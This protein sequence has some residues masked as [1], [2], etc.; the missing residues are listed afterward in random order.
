MIR[1]EIHCDG[2][3][4]RNAT[5][6]EKLSPSCETQFVDEIVSRIVDEQGWEVS[7]DGQRIICNDCRNYN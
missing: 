6:S 4:C 3:N 2:N 1:L 5:W 7:S